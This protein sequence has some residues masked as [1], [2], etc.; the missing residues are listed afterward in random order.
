MKRLAKDI[1]A[2]FENLCESGFSRGD[3]VKA[4]ADKFG[5]PK[6]KIYALCMKK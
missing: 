5:L 4:A 6:N 2:F 1:V 3:A